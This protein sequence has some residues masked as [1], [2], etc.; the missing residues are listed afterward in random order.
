MNGT[1]MDVAPPVKQLADEA[2]A[3]AFRHDN[4]DIERTLTRLLDEHGS[5]GMTGAMAVW[6][7]T[8]ISQTGGYRPGAT[9]WLEFETAEDGT[10]ND[11]DSVD[12]ATAWAGRLI[13]ARRA[14][15]RDQW[16]ALLATMP[17]DDDIRGDYLVVLL[18]C[19]A[20]TLREAM[21]VHATNTARDLDRPL[22]QAL[23]RN[24]HWN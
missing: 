10:V 1:D 14:C 19:V 11:A 6:C 20:E 13:T 15:D 22:Y 3:A 24:A 9:M 5:T 8:L 4:D 16:L 7:D 12:P 17:D 21:T 2:L 18:A 23:R